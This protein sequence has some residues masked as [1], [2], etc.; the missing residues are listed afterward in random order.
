M[1]KDIWFNILLHVDCV[2]NL[3]SLACVNHL[4]YHILQDYYFWIQLYNKYNLI[5]PLIKCIN[6][7]SLKTTLITKDYIDFL[8]KPME[9][10][11]NYLQCYVVDHNPLKYVH[12]NNL[13]HSEYADIP[14]AEI[15]YTFKHHKVKMYFHKSVYTIDIIDCHHMIYDFINNDIKIEKDTIPHLKYLN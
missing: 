4:L 12:V 14:Y 10:G 7:K 13:T 11:R 5:T 15:I 6:I 1:N 9:N 3:Q 8:L 2:I